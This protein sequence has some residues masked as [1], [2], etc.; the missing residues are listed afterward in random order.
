[1]VY[2]CVESGCSS[3]YHTNRE[4]VL[5]FSFPLGKSDLL[6]KWVKFVNLNDWYYLPTPPLGQ[7]MTQ[8]QFLSGV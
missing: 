7:D 5:T 3:G 1:M 6:E 2:N 4:K 8:G